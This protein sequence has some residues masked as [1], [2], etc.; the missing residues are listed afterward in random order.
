MGHYNPEEMKHGAMSSETRHVGDW[1]N[2]DADE[3]VEAEDQSKT[4]NANV[5]FNSNET[6]LHG[7]HSIL[8][9]TIVVHNEEDDLGVG[10][11][12]GSETTGNAG[13]RAACC[14]ITR[15]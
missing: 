9:R 5:D 6:S 11:D 15:V 10:G 1:G 14:V 4:Y 2:I 7:K 8:G 13:P 3:L 12:E